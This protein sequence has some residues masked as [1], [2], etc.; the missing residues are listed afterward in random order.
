MASTTESPEEG[1]PLQ[2]LFA[3]REFLLPAGAEGSVF[4]EQVSDPAGVILFSAGVLWEWVIEFSSVRQR[5][6]C[7]EEGWRV[8]G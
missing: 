1:R 7:E 5:V 4:V 6:G 2:S 8:D 3:P